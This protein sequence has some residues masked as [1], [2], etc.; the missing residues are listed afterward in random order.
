MA[1]PSARIVS[2][3]SQRIYRPVAPHTSPR[4]FSLPPCIFSRIRVRH[5]WSPRFFIATAR[6]NPS[7]LALGGIATRAIDRRHEDMVQYAQ[8]EAAEGTPQG[9]NG[10]KNAAPNDTRFRPQGLERQASSERQSWVG[11]PTC[12]PTGFSHGYLTLRYA[13]EGEEDMHKGGG[14]A[15][16]RV[17]RIFDILHTS[18]AGQGIARCARPNDTT[19]E[20]ETK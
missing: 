3:L 10:L 17:Q 19:T 4:G 2:V 18:Q 12:K 5:L 1:E 13:F 9:E 15:P 8:Q 16:L 7:A 6:G 14:I 20:T 11:Q